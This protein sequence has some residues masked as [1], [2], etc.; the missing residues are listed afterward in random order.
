VKG[1]MD[2]AER[3]AEAIPLIVVFLVGVAIFSYSTKN[4]WWVVAALVAVFVIYC[5][6]KIGRE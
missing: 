1:K 2:A 6:H 4:P 3:M 5:I